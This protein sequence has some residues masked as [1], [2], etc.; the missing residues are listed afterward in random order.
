MTPPTASAPASP[1]SRRTTA[2]TR[3]S[4]RG[5]PRDTATSITGRSARSP[6]HSKPRPRSPP[7]PHCATA[8]WPPPS[9]TP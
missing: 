5:S 2:A 8:P 1:P 9:R 6:W 4:R 3:A 7:P